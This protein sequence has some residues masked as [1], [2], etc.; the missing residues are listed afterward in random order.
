MKL[1]FIILGICVLASCE[2][3]VKEGWKEVK[4]PWDSKHYKEVMRKLY[5]R[6]PKILVNR[7][8]RIAGEKL[9]I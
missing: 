3:E 7:N 4:F 2:V 8:G 5:P 6:T 9:E 1:I